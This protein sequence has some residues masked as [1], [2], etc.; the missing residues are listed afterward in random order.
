MEMCL[1]C[2]QANHKE[3]KKR[4]GTGLITLN[5]SL[6]NIIL[7]L[8]GSRFLTLDMIGILDWIIL[9]VRGCPRR[10]PDLY[11]R[12]ASSILP[13]PGCDSCLQMLPRQKSPLVQESPLQSKRE[14]QK[15]V[16]LIGLPHGG[17]I[18]VG[19]F[20]VALMEWVKQ[21]KTYKK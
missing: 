1:L 8:P 4:Q 7:T 19:M 11:P 21:N 18:G 10:I 17:N 20:T 15:C 5:Y 2:K 16:I 12:G 14:R 6:A 3:E 13:V 9:V